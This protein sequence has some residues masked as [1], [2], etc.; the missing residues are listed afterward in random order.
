[1]KLIMVLGGAIGF[2]IGLGFS[3]AQGSPW[4]SVLWRA[5][6]AA[7]LAGILLRWWGRL[8]IKCLQDSHRERL[9][10][11]KQRASVAST[12]PNPALK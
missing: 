6:I 5:A 9:A 1:M 10:A 11:A 8:W 4:P 3:W 7:L 2:S 12:Q